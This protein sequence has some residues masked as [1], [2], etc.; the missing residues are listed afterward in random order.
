MAVVDGSTNKAGQRGYTVTALE[1]AGKPWVL[2]STT[3]D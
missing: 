2:F 3:L 1:G